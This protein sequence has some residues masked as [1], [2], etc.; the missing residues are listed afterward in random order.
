MWNKDEVKGKGKKAGGAV[1]EKIGKVT[2]NPDLE[3]EGRSDRQEGEL[4][5]SFAK[6]RR[7]A[8]EAVEK[9]GKKIS[10]G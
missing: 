5:E 4:Q 1:K 9:V 7:K 10:R 2:R 6:V 8:G 3:E